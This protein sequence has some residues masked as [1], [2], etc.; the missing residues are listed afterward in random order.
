MLASPGQPPHLVH[1]AEDVGIVLLEAPDPR[2][3]RQGPRGLVAMEHPEVGQPQG[4]LPP[5][6]GPV[7]EHEAVKHEAR[8][9]LPEGTFLSFPDSR[10]GWDLRGSSQG[11]G[12]ASGS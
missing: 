10:S 6:S 8:S 1:G 9:Q 12:F 5:G 11:T 2:Q 3:P 4:Q 7:G